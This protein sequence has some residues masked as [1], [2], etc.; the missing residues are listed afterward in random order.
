ME[1]K[2]INTD[3]DQTFAKQQLK[4]W[5]SLRIKL[6]INYLQHFHQKL[7]QL[8]NGTIHQNLPTI[9]DPVRIV[10]LTAIMEKYLP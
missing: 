1:E 6:K 7:K 3:N 9:H 5:V 4:C 2:E 8:T 10:F